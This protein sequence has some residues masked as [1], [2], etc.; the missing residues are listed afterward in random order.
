M[1]F[2][3]VASATQLD[4][5][6]LVGLEL[7]AAVL[8]VALVG[9]DGLD[10]VD[11]ALAEPL[12]EV[13]L[14]D[15]LVEAVGGEEHV[16]EADVARLVHAHGARLELLAREAEVVLRD[17]EQV[18]VLADLLLDGGEAV[19]GLVVALD[20]Q[21]DLGVERF[22]LGGD[23]ARAS[24]LLGDRRG[25]RDRGDG[26]DEDEDA[27][28]EEERGDCPSH[29]VHCIASLRARAEACCARVEVSG[30]SGVRAGRA[31]SGRPSHIGRRP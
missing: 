6:L 25:A 12:H 18:L 15:E 26:E 21:G 20:G 5:R 8:D 9:G 16:D 28:E 30:Q 1:F 27:G 19:H 22:E 10:G 3:A 29:A 23:L 4:R 13:E 31:D 17:L 14:G 7:E 2:S 11:V 24:L